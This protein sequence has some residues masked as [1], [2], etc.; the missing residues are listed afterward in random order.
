MTVSRPI[1]VTDLD[2]TLLDHQ[3]YSFAAAQSAIDWLVKQAYPL[4]INSSKTRAEILAL[5]QQLALSQ[6]LICENGAA[7]YVPTVTR[8]NLE[9]R[10]YALADSRQAWLPRIAELRQR[11][12]Y[13]FHGFS[14]WSVADV[15]AYTGLSA[16]QAR[17][18]K[19]REF[20]EPLLWQDSPERL[21]SFRQQVAE[22]GLQL[23]QGGRFLS[24]QGHFDKRD[25][26]DWLRTHYRGVYGQD[27]TIIALGDSPNDQRMLDA[28]DIA[29]II[30]S[31]KSSQLKI[32]Q[33]ERVIRT[34]QQGPVGWQQAMTEIF[35]Q[36][37]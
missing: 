22:L 26:L 7:I 21:E 18:A 6:P 37:F 33:A 32:T 4:I 15:V 2:G 20:T 17:L 3:T 14:D 25:A 19:Q 10:S 12:N 8:G 11:Y 23:V 34:A 31:E 1:V 5:Q 30:K 9:W 28:A 24:L 27:V 29:V 36:Q 16:E 35:Q 13:R